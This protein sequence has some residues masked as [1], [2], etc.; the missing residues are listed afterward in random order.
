MNKQQYQYLTLAITIILIGY[1]LVRVTNFAAVYGGVEHDG[2]WMLTISRSLAEQGTYTTMVSTIA[3]PTVEGA[4]N[5]DDKFD[6]QADDGRIWFFTGNG[7][8]PASIIPDAFVIKLFGSSF[9]GLKAGPLI[10]YTLFLALACLILYRLAGLFAIVLFHLYLFFYPHISIFLGYEA[11]GEVP[12]MTYILWAYL[13]FAWAVEQANRVSS[14]DE[15]SSLSGTLP[16]SIPPAR[17]EVAPPP[18]RGIEE[19]R[20]S[21]NLT[22]SL[23]TRLKQSPLLPFFLAGLVI[24]LALNAKLIALWSVSGII[25]WSGLLWLSR[26]IDFRQLVALGTG[27]ALLVILWELVHLVVLTSLT[28][29]ELYQQNFWQRVKFVLDD[30]SGVGLQIHAGPEFMWDKFYLL[31]EVAHPDRWATMFIFMM[32]LCG[33]LALIYLRRDT[34]YLQNLLAPMWLGWLANTVWFVSLAKTGWPRHFWFGLVLAILLSSII[35]ISFLKQGNWP[36]RTT[37]PKNE[38]ESDGR[39]FVRILS[40][41]MLH[42]S[43][44]LMLLFVVWGFISQP[45]VWGF[46]LP[47]EIVPYWQQKQ[48]TNKYHASLPWVIIPRAEQEAVVNYIKQMPAEAKVYFPS[49]HKNA[50]LPAQTG[51]LQYPIKRRDLT[52]A[53]P[54]DVALIGPSLISPW[55]DPVRR[56]DLLR[57]VRSQCPNPAIENDFY[58][59]CVIEQNQVAE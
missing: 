26:R 47:D 19:G 33:S 46:Y 22:A 39:Y 56:A 17:G 34:P 45:Y 40:H 2:G 31:A 5:V 11:M 58:M 35:L 15:V 1:Q 29:F 8:G 10:F 52:S 21:A 23:W 57:L 44:R 43:A 53:H 4:M 32:I 42:V 7:I 20:D 38:G 24:S 50:E 25:V 48:I 37:V 14:K 36:T 51:R 13:T 49:G 55:M 16:P 59:V 3:D 6:I 28:S 30:G 9:W 41:S 18:S 12:A 27:T 54:Q